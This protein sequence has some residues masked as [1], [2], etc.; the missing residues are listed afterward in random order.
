TNYVANWN[1]LCRSEP[2]SLGYTAPPQKFANV[3]DGLSNTIMIGEAY[4]WCEGRGRTAFLAWHTGQ[5]GFAAPSRNGVHNFGLTF[6]LTN[7]SV[8]AGNGPVSVTVSN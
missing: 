7:A 6:N 4:A 1:M 8:D 3:T 5:G 2:A